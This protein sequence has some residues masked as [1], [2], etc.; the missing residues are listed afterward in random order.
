MRLTIGE[1]TYLLKLR[2]EAVEHEMEKHPDE[3]ASKS[4]SNLSMRE[5]SAAL[6]R[7]RRN[8]ARTTHRKCRTTATLFLLG[9]PSE[10]QIAT[11]SVSNC[12]DDQF[13]AP[14]GRRE[15]IEKLKLVLLDLPYWTHEMN[16][17]LTI[18]FYERYP[19]SRPIHSK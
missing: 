18:A 15:A 4:L 14:R 16:R 17:A 9:G 10:V 6:S 1:N 13:N 11:V 3:V 12:L 19:N 7:M 2:T 8:K 5:L